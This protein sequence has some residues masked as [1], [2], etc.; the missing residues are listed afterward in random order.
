M[1]MIG[2]K[3]TIAGF[4]STILEYIFFLDLFLKGTIIKSIRFF[5]LVTSKSR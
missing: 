3:V 4:W 5:S 1:T 2:T